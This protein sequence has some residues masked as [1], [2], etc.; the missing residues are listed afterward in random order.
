MLAIA[1]SGCSDEDDDNMIWEPVYN[2]DSGMIEVVIDNN[3][4]DFDSF[5]NIWVKAGYKSGDVDLRCVNHPINWALIGPNDSY[6]NPDM[7]FILSKVNDYTLRIHFEEDASGKPENTD[8]ITITNADQ[9]PIVCNTL[10]WI[11]RT[12][13]ELN[14]SQPTPLPQ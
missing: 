11:T 1:L 13:G 7:N 5:P 9:K 4:G 2:S 8:E 3:D 6:R 12:Y 14:P 10:L